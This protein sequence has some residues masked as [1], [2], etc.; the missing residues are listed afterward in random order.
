VTGK[1]GAIAM[2]ADEL[3]VSADLVWM[4]VDAQFPRWRGRPASKR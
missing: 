2:H 3:P 4:L 1:L